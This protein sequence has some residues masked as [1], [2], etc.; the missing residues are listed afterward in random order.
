MI[1][2]MKLADLDAV[3]SIYGEG[4]K[5]GC[6]TFE[7]TIPS[8]EKWDSS[9]HKTLRFVAE[10]GEQVVGWV[11]LSPIS[12][13]QAY[14]GVGEISIYVRSTY[15]GTGVAS[16]LMEKMIEQSEKEGFWTLQSSIFAINKPS[17]TLHKKM[18]FRTVGT[19]K[20]IAQLYGQWHDTVIMERRSENIF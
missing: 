16:L 1:R 10:A 2:Q 20:K 18:G 11:T 8:K 14:S 15:R 5:T 4:L 12:T 17:I 9:Q 19:R 13:R 6:A 7:T 3:L